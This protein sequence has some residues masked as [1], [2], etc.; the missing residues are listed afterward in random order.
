MNL[1]IFAVLPVK[2]IS[3]LSSLK[4]LA[5]LVPRFQSHDF[6]IHWLLLRAHLWW[7][8]C[9]YFTSL[10]Y[11]AWQRLQFLAHSAWTYLKQAFDTWK[12]LN[13]WS[14]ITRGQFEITT[15]CYY[16]IIWAAYHLLRNTQLSWRLCRN[17]KDKIWKKK[18]VVNDWERPPRK[19]IEINERAHL[20]DYGDSKTE[21]WSNKQR[22]KRKVNVIYL[23]PQR[24]TKQEL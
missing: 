3:V 14:S 21:H 11:S 12:R 10:P 20:A 4:P 16:N 9:P 23:C 18:W 6:I 8:I 19:G 17:W 5:H 15:E 2:G 24:T 13:M 22:F 1:R 7:I